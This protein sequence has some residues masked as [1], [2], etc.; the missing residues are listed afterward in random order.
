MNCSLPGS[1]FHEDSPGKNTGVGC[2]ALLQGVFPNQ[3]WNPGLL[4]CR[5]ILYRQSHQGSPWILEWV[6]YPFSRGS[7]WLRNR[8]GVSFIAGG[9]FTSWAPREA[10]YVLYTVWNHMHSLKRLNQILSW[11]DG[12]LSSRTWKKQYKSRSKIR[13]AIIVNRLIVVVI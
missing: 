8:T 5:R 4:H 13:R 9:F 11:G 2:R 6:D 7:S 12:I 1:S 10:H 3:G